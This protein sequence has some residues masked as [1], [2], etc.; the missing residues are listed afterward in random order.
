MKENKEMKPPAD[1]QAICDD[2]KVCGRREMSLLIRMR[3]KFQE[4]LKKAKKA[5]N[6]AEVAKAKAL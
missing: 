3:H 2:I 1:L 4:L 6:D 5:I